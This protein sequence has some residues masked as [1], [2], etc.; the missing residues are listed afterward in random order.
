MSEIASNL[1][2]LLLAF[3]FSSVFVW[4]GSFFSHKLHLEPA[5]LGISAFV[6][7]FLF[8]YLRYVRMLK[9]EIRELRIGSHRREGMGKE[10]EPLTPGSIEDAERNREEG[11][12]GKEP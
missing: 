1:L 11:R 12:N 7:V 8:C 5:E 9:A 4:L 10:G 3:A 6:A 2:L